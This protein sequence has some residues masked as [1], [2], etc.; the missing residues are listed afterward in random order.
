M[1][2]LIR[3]VWARLIHAP[4]PNN[5]LYADSHRSDHL[6]GSD[7]NFGTGIN[8]YSNLVKILVSISFDIQSFSPN[9][10]YKGRTIATPFL[11]TAGLEDPARD[12]RLLGNCVYSSIFTRFHPWSFK[13]FFTGTDN[14]GHY[15][16][17]SVLFGA[18]KERSLLSKKAVI[19]YY[20][21][22]ISGEKRISRFFSKYE[23][24]ESFARKIFMES[25]EEK[26]KN[27]FM[28]PIMTSSIR[29]CIRRLKH[30]IGIFAYVQTM[31]G[32][33]NA[34]EL[35]FDFNKRLRHGGDA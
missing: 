33:I 7:S 14:L 23:E 3:F 11:S 18:D 16:F 15:D 1:R 17:N 5:L 19:N 26:V 2:S 31:T 25:D 13:E 35:L 30:P 20:V 28:R 27:F 34:S 32:S 6:I 24:A 29:S 12:R 21:V 8:L 10:S 9:F 4:H 22:D